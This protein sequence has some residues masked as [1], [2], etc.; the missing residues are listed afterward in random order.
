[1]RTPLVP[2]TSIVWT[3]ERWSPGIYRDFWIRLVGALQGMPV[4]VSSYWRDPAVNAEVNGSPN[5]QHLIGLGIDLVLTDPADASQ[6][7]AGLNHRGLLAFNEGTHV[8]V[9][10]WPAGLARQ[11]GLLDALGF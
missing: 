5:S 3:V 6:A 11:V 8:H 4:G 9:Q 2:P 1:M 7:T 10:A